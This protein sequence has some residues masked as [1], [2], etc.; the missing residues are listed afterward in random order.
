MQSYTGLTELA[1]ISDFIDRHCVHLDIVDSWE[2]LVD[3]Y[4]TLSFVDKITDDTRLAEFREIIHEMNRFM[5]RSKKGLQSAESIEAAIDFLNK[6]FNTKDSANVRTRSQLTYNKLKQRWIRQSRHY[7]EAQR[8][9][10]FA[11]E[12]EEEDV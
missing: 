7:L 1:I 11:I 2:T 12:T 9:M 5:T 3:V 4:E 6:Q 8:E 10:L